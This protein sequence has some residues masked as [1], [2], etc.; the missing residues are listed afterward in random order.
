MDLWLEWV[1]LAARRSRT[2]ILE[3]R[4]EI[5]RTNVEKR[6]RERERERNEWGKKE[7]NFF[8]IRSSLSWS[9]SL[10]GRRS[11]YNVSCSFGPVSCLFFDTERLS[12]PSQS[13]GPRA[14]TNH[15]KYRRDTSTSGP[16]SLR[17]RN[18]H[19]NRSCP[20]SPP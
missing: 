18:F 3:S 16:A 15:T 1:E 20:I 11:V 13:P 9:S 10:C 12:W 8:D 5:T 6:E 17:R 2:L 7:R 4:S 14:P 19:D